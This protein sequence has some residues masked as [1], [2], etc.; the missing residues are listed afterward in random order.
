MLLARGIP[1]RG[2]DQVPPPL[3]RAHVNPVKKGDERGQQGDL[4][5]GDGDGDDGSGRSGTW[6]WLQRLSKCRCRSR[7]WSGHLTLIQ[8]EASIRDIYFIYFAL[9]LLQQG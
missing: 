6:I 2:Q 9:P 3:R 7:A 8:H 1:R 5:R 4:G